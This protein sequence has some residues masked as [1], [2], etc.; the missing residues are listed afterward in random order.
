MKY[1][2]K[3]L[4][5]KIKNILDTPD[6]YST[7]FEKGKYCYL[8]SATFILSLAIYHCFHRP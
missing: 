5:T 6:L 2:S 8:D 1:L 3:L 4:N 7:I